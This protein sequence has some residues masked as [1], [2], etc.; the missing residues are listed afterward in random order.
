MKSMLTAVEKKYRIPILD[1]DTSKKIR[2]YQYKR[3]CTKYAC[4]IRSMNIRP[5]CV[6]HQSYTSMQYNQRD[7]AT[8]WKLGE[9]PISATKS[10]SSTRRYKPKTV[11]ELEWKDATVYPS[12]LA[13]VDEHLS[14]AWQ[15]MERHHVT[16][17]PLL[18]EL[19][20]LLC[21]P[22]EPK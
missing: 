14:L 2:E 19:C 4:M 15:Q 16:K 3:E 17:P 11:S 9:E 22:Y 18:D 20:Q 7:S 6:Q 13:P 21:W 5:V 10:R 12:R 8:M 1:V